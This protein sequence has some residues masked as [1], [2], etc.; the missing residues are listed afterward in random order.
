[1]T[2]ASDA[3]ID[4]RRLKRQMVWWRLAALLAVL[5][6]GLIAVF[7]YDDDL[8][9]AGDR[10]ARLNIEGPIMEDRELERVLRRLAEDDRVR[11]VMVR[12]N[13]PGGS[14]Y[15]GETLYRGLR[16]FGEWKPVVAVIG[17]LGA[18]AGY[19]I[20]LA[21]DRIWARETSLTGSIG[22]IMQTGEISG[23]LEKLGITAESLTS[24]RLKDEPSLTR[25][26]SPEGRAVLLA[27]IERTHEWFVGLVAERRQMPRDQAGRL[28]TGQIYTGT[29][30]L[31][32]RLIDELGGEEEALAWLSTARGISRD[33][34]VRTVR[35]G[36]QVEGWADF[37]ARMFR[38]VVA[39]ER[40]NLDGL[41]SVWQP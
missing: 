8:P 28:A 6:A 4:R 27:T 37:G 9:F 3:L 19:L 39:A 40:L 36:D 1:M 16:R 24:G 7:R 35:F 2:L 5:V 29:Q 13:S 23:L 12:I 18:S 15:G 22:V 33:L 11:A 30:A 20:A 25:R 38:K 41:M 21:G 10:I 26:L 17:T 31:E 32:V 34:P 14:T